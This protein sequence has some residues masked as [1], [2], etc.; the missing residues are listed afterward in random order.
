MGRKTPQLQIYG[1][2][3]C[4]KVVLMMERGHCFHPKTDIMFS[5]SV[6]TCWDDTVLPS[7][8]RHSTNDP[9]M[10]SLCSVWALVSEQ[11]AF[12][13][14]HCNTSNWGSLRV[15]FQ[16]QCIPNQDWTLGYNLCRF[17]ARQGQIVE[18]GQSM[19]L[20]CSS[21]ELMKAQAWNKQVNTMSLSTIVFQQWKI[22]CYMKE[23]FCH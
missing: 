10:E 6:K 23:N 11:K 19:G 18:C 22:I 9:T 17:W 13:Q 21:H 2:Q 3:L 4:W 5:I 1:K 8:M 14:I 15:S 7:D 16:V 20:S 12:Y